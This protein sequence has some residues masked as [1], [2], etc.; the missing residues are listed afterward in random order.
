[1]GKRIQVSA[2]RSFSLVL[3]ALLGLG[4]LASPA[5]AQ[6]FD[7][8]PFKGALFTQGKMTLKGAVTDSYNSNLGPYDPAT[9]GNNGDIGSNG[10]ISLGSGAVVKG[11]A[12]AVGSISGSGGVT[13]TV[14]QGAPPFPTPPTP[15][16]PTGGYTPAQYIPSGPGVSYNAS[17]G[18]LV[19]QGGHSLTLTAPPTKYYFSS[20]SI[21]GGSTLSVNG[22]GQQVQIWIDNQLTLSG[23]GILNTDAKA[24]LLGWWACGSNTSKW[25]IS[26]GSNAYFTM[27][28]PLHQ[29][30][31]S[32]GNL[33]GAAVAASLDGSGFNFHFD[34][35]LTQ[36]I[37]PGYGVVVAPHADT[38]SRLP[39]TNY[40][41]SFTVQNV[42]N[43]TDSYDL[44]TSRLPG[45]A[46]TIVSITG[47]GVTQG[48][49]PDS[50]RLA[51]VAAN[52]TVTVTVHY[53]VAGGAVGPSDTLVFTAR[54]VASPTS[55]DN[56]RLT[57]T[58]LGHGAVV[59][60]HADSVKHLPSNGTNYT[61][62][63]TVQNTGNTLDNF[64]LLTKKRPGTALTTVSIT[65]TG[66]TQG[67]NPDSARLA[68][69]AGSAT[70]AVTVTYTVGN[71]AAGTIDTLVFTARSVTTPASSDSGKLVLTVVRPSLAIGR[72]VSPNSSLAPGTVLTYT[73]TVTNG[74]T[75]N[76]AGVALVDTLAPA[77]QFKVGS[78]VTTLPTGV[79]AVLTYSNDGGTTWTYVP[80]SAACSAPAGYDRCV[81]RIRWQLQNALSYTAPDNTGSLQFVAQIR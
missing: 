41:R 1:M 43:T 7:G 42:G 79:T 71:V 9:A 2:A 26:G 44:L 45:T 24:P 4:A 28:A 59:A 5:A 63:F 74:G 57:V 36:V 61:A 3:L 65:G 64:D 51:N 75:S 38:V 52:A 25:T 67:S 80:V 19:V 30:S 17:T 21:T 72:T 20:V 47:S 77:V 10:D 15:P 48:S 54:S 81:N 12:T 68:N 22:G 11:D 35:A 78:A 49:N 33:F 23:G 76:A 66:V 73:L 46:L 13:G 6:V 32:N 37:L 34:E 29:L 50:A 55:K 40:T 39:G 16:C 62:S 8:F 14:T 69:L 60:P 56:G 27:Y 70:A 58:V 31:F 53:N 18:V